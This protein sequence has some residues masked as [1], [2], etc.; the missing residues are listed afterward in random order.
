MAFIKGQKPYPHKEKCICPRCNPQKL[1]EIGFQKG[2]MP[3][4]GFKKGQ[5]GWNKGTKGIM[6]PNKTS[7][8]KGHIAWFI[9][10]NKPHPAIGQIKEGLKREKSPRW[11][12]GITP[13]TQKLRNSERYKQWRE[14]V[15]K[16]DNYTCQ[17]CGDN[18]G[19]NLNAH[20]IIPFAECMEIDFE[21]MIFNIDNGITYCEECH[22]GIKNG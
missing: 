5:K 14:T 3:I 10:Q 15:Y 16:R 20:H 22:G 13:Y 11:K 7:F 19:G 1:R 8:K 6:K 21:D 2:H 12:G 4:C 9:K 18:K 17:D